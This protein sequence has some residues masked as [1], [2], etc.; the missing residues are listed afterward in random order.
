MSTATLEKT[1]KINDIDFDEDEDYLTPQEAW[2]E[3]KAE[4]DDIIAHPEKYKFYD[5]V[6]E[7]LRDMGFDVSNLKDD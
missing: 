2:D 1:K 6:K 4:C 3:V 5:S 7:M